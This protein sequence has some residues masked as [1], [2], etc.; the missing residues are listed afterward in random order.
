MSRLRIAFGHPLEHFDLSLAQ[1][2]AAEVLGE[3]LRD[4]RRKMLAAE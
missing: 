3:R 2:I 1:R 4:L